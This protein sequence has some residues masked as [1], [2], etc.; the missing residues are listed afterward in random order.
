MMTSMSVI[1][2]LIVEAIPPKTVFL[3]FL[4]ELSELIDETSM[5]A[6]IIWYLSAAFY[7]DDFRII[8]KRLKCCF[9]INSNALTLVKP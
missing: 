5:T 1:S 8:L 9:A 6:I 4:T 3:E 2:L 7:V